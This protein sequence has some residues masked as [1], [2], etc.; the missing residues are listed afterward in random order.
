V[1]LL[2]AFSTRLGLGF[3]TPWYL[4]ELAV[5]HLVSFPFLLV[6]ACWV[7]VAGQLIALAT[8]RYAPLPMRRRGAP[9][10]AL[11]RS[12]GRIAHVGRS[13]SASRRRALEG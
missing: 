4:M 2:H 13:A 5:V 1:W 6:F 8:G 7:A 3:D 10:T 9:P 12:V 11:R